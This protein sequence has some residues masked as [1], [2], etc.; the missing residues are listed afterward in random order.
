MLMRKKSSVHPRR[1]GEHRIRKSSRKIILGSSPQARG[2]RQI[3][4]WRR[5]YPRFIP[6]GAGNTSSSSSRSSLSSVHPRRR[7]EHR[8]DPH[9]RSSGSGSSPQARGTHLRELLMSSLCRFIP[10]GAGNTPPVSLRLSRTSVH[11]RR[12]GEHRLLDAWRHR[13]DGSSPQARGTQGLAH[14]QTYRERFIPA[15]AGNT[16]VSCGPQAQG[17]VHPRRRGEH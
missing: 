6:A 10:A 13:V 15:G 11:P 17:P 2:T 14:S 4:F 7:G 3:C 8:P 16:G 1:R 9:S 12:R 5:R